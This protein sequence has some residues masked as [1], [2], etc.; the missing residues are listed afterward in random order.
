MRELVRDQRK[1]WVPRGN[2]RLEGGFRWQ[3]KEEVQKEKLIK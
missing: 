2:R 1:Q 3:R